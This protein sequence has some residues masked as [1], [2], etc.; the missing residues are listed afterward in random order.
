[1]RKAFAL[2][3]AAIALALSTPA[4]AAMLVIDGNGE[5]A[6]ATD[7][8]VGGTLY[9]VTFA[10]G[11]C[12]SLFNGCDQLSDFAF[13]NLASAENAA[14]ALLAQVFA[15]NPAYSSA[16]ELTAGCE[17][18]ELCLIQIPY[19]LF[20]GTSLVNQRSAFNLSIGSDTTGNGA[21]DSDFDTT[22]FD[23]FT[24]AVFT[25]S[26]SDAVPEPAT[27]AMMLMGFG[28]VGFALRRRRKPVLQV[29]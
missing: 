7:V 12:I 19:G 26:Q 23:H 15:P 27:W 20:P 5:L 9:N 10:E 16:P 29:A 18:K 3:G 24:Y 11:S 22:A 25:P 17:N 13:Q 28:A 21:F 14:L 4:S 1:M 8:D 2:V 6:G